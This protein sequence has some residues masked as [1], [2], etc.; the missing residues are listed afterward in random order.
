MLTVVGYVDRVALLA[1]IALVIFGWLGPLWIV[2]YLAAPV[3]ASVSALVR[4]SDT[5]AKWV[6][7]FVAPPM[8]VVDIAASMSSTLLSLIGRRVEW[9]TDRAD[10]HREIVSAKAADG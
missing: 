5:G 10:G 2:A 4:A 7:L 9:K 6:Y 1:A 3:V 8:F